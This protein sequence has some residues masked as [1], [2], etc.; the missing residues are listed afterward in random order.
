MVVMYN[1]VKYAARP[2]GTT[3]NPHRQVPAVTWS[4]GQQE[5]DY[6]Q[7]Y[8]KCWDA[9]IAARP[10]AESLVRE[11]DDWRQHSTSSTTTPIN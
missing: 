3:T 7:V 6:R 8:T 5:S 2:D 4:D 1:V 10:T 9:D 11:F